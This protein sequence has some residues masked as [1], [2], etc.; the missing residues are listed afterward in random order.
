[1][2]V[3]A[4]RLGHESIETTHIYLEADLA[5]K[6]RTLERI[7]FVAL[8]Q[9]WRVLLAWSSTRRRLYTSHFASCGRRLAYWCWPIRLCQ[10]L[11]R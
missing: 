7:D 4:L 1:M 5:I 2:V 3:I 10:S 6:E 9:S 8:L 11:G